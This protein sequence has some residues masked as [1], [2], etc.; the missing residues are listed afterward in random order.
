MDLE[1]LLTEYNAAR[2][3]ADMKRQV[4]ARAERAVIEAQSA[5]VDAMIEAGLTQYGPIGSRTEW[6]VPSETFRRVWFTI[7]TAN[8]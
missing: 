8:H 2:A 3:E 7:E 6:H 1:T 4:A 5:L